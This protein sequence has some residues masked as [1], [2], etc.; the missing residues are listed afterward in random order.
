VDRVWNRARELGYERV[1]RA[2][3]RYSM[4]DD[5]IPLQ[6]VGI[7][8]IDVIQFGLPYWHTTEDTFDKVSAE[9][10]EMVGDVAVAL[11]R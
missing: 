1:F 11:L 5:H 2:Q 9:S 10:L 3:V 6:E 8:A 4:V 7:R